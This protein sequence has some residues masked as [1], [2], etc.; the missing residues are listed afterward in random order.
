MK[1]V[2]IPTPKPD[3]VLDEVAVDDVTYKLML[4]VDEAVTPWCVDK[5]VAGKPVR[6][7]RFGYS[8]ER[9]AR[10][11]FAIFKS[12]KNHSVVRDSDESFEDYMTR[13]IKSVDWDKA[14]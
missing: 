5:F 11:K 6:V 13:Q 1:N 10:E 7:Q 12:Y 9:A 14:K 4:I 2:F 3:K 8:T